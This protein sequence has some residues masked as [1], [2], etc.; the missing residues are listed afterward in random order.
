M[1]NWNT[2]ENAIRESGVGYTI[3]RASWFMETLHL[4][5][6]GDRALSSGKQASPVHWITA[7]DYAEMVSKAYK[8]EASENKT[9]FE[10]TNNNVA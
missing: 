4:F 7:A 6:R 2:K 1:I 8:I 10:Y 3:L 5:V 9:L